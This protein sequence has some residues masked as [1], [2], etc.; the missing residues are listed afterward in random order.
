MHVVYRERRG[1][2]DTEVATDLGQSPAPLAV[3]SFSDSDLG[4][5][6]AGWHDA[7]GGLPPLRLANLATLKHPLSV[8][9]YLERTLSGARGVLVRL[10]GGVGYWSY[11][12]G[13]VHDLARR[14][15]MALA[16]LPGDGRED[17]ALDALSTV[18]VTTLRRLSALCDAG[19]AMAARAALAELAREAGLPAPDHAGETRVPECGWYRPGAGPVDAPVG[20]PGPFVAV[21]FYRSYLTSGDTGPVDA[22]IA[23]LETRGFRAAGW[24]VPSLKA[25]A[26]AAATRAALAAT[27]PVGIVNATAFAARDETGS[28]PL[29]TPGCPVFQV[30]LST[31]RRDEWAG[32]E[33]G[34]SPADLAMHVVLP[35]TDGRIFAGVASFK[36]AGETDPDLQFAR[37]VHEADAERIAAIA[38][39]VAAWHALA[40]TSREERRLAFIL[41]TYPG[42]AD[43][44][45]H[46]VGLDTLASVEAILSACSDEGYALDPGAPLARA[47]A[48]AAIDWPLASYRA[49]LAALPKALQADLAA[50]WGEP[51]ADPMVENGAFRFTAIRRGRALVALQ[52]ERGTSAAREDDYHDLSRTPCHGY[53][54]F[55]LW[56]R[57]QGID[58]LVHVGAHGTMEWLPGKAVALSDTCWPEAL[59][60]PL[61]VVYPFIVNDPGEAAQAKR[62]IGAVT[63]GHVPPPLRSSALPDRLQTLERLLDEYSTAEGLDPARRDRLIA[64]IRAEAQASGVEADLDLA[65]DA[66]AAEAMVRIDRFVCD[67]KESRFGDGLHVYGAAPGEMAGLIAA[68]DGR[69]V[70][71][72]PSGSPARGRT[73]VLPTGR[74]LYAVDPRAVPSRVAH[75]QGVK[76]AEELLR[77]HMQDHGDWPR[78][79]V[80]DLWGSASMRTAGEEFAMALHL[81]GLAPRWDAGSERLCGFEILPPALLGRPRI[82][83]TLRVSG[84]FRDVFPTLAQMFEAATAALSERTDEPAD[85]NPYLARAP[86]VFGPR[87]GHY[88]LGMADPADHLSDADRIAAGEAWLSASAW[89]IDAQGAIRQDREG[90]EARMAGADAFTHVQDLPETDVLMARDYA[91]H[92]GGFAAAK[93]RLGQAEPALYH[94]DATRPERPVARTQA[95]EIARVVRTRAADPAWADGMMRHG[96]RG[97]AEIAATLDNMAAFSRLGDT[98]GAHLFDLYFDATLGREDVVA[99][100]ARENPQALAQIEARFAALADAGL[101]VTRRNSIVARLER[102]A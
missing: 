54:A 90:L 32:A 53:V 57:A 17:P 1:L 42:R 83:V 101:W 39:R 41:S 74:N 81:A 51:D 86:R 71:P 61:P 16:V 100:M 85:E 28:S 50:A 29:D 8:D 82:D 79:L 14:T 96:F 38:D 37:V 21:A 20:G 99:F 68:L 5:F 56:L 63:L 88:G 35:E 52:P 4:A 58:A 44:M 9:T 30:A 92:E 69:R 26:A 64:A 25:P 40:T 84:L 12:L 3:L 78:G 6:A 48:E 75:A 62:R 11:G 76:L 66:G 36:S 91:T 49:A 67:I 43:Q 23:A 19:G 18:P 24:F 70:E 98:V 2:E 34:L 87:P 73:D 45:A 15:G 72:G 13:Q 27:G 93:A 65:A 102:G 47:L 97:A 89:S 55:Y 59:T 31:A 95:E 46:A 94:L 10:I 77:R 22:L 33:R 7:R 80:I 60:G